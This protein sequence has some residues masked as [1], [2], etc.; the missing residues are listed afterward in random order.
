M[1][2]IKVKNVEDFD[3]SL[4][5]ASYRT[6]FKTDEEI[7]EFIEIFCGEGKRAN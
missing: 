7:Q 5:F 3:K 1:Q 4:I 2:E 6:L